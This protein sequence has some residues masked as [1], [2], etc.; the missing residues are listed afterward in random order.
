MSATQS[1]LIATLL[2][3]LTPAAAAQSAAQPAPP[4]LPDPG[5][6]VLWDDHDPDALWASAATYKACFAADRVDYIPLLGAHAPSLPLRLELAEVTAGAQRVRLSRA[7]PT[8]HG[9]RVELD[10]GPVRERWELGPTQAEQSFVLHEP[11]SPGDLRLSLAVDTELEFAGTDGEGLRFSAR[12]ATGKSLGE[13]RYGHATVLDARGR[14]L[15]SPVRWDG[16]AIVIHV[17]G[18]FLEQAAWPVTIDPV[19]QTFAVAAN[20]REQH[21]SDSTYV[22][23]A[24]GNLWVVVYEERVSLIDQDIIARRY[25]EAGRFVDELA[26]EVAPSL[27]GRPSVATNGSQARAVI[28]WE[29]IAANGNK[30][31]LAREINGNGSLG[32]AFTVAS[33]TVD[34]SLPDV[35]GATNTAVD[36]NLSLIVWEAN[37]TAT[38]RDVV[39]RIYDSN[40]RT[41][42]PLLTLANSTAQ[43]RNARVNKVRSSGD[44]W[45]VVFEAG[46]QVR[47][48]PVTS[49]GT[50]GAAFDFGTGAVD[51]QPDVAGDGTSFLVVVARTVGAATHDLFAR[52]LQRRGLGFTGPAAFDLTAL[53]PG[54]VP[55]LDQ[56]SPRIDHDGT[57]YSY[58][59]IE[60]TAASGQ[61][62]MAATLRDDGS[63]LFD[64]G[65]VQVAAGPL[66]HMEPAI[67]ARRSGNGG[68]GRYLVTV[69][70]P[71]STTPF[72][73]NIDALLWNGTAPQG[74]VQ[75]LVTGCG[76]TLG[77]GPPALTLFEESLPPALGATLQ[78]FL[79]AQ[80]G[81]IP[82]YLVGFPPSSLPIPLCPGAGS[83]K[84]G[85]TTF[86]FVLSANH[87]S[88]PIPA[89][90]NLLGARLAVQGMEVFT[91]AR[92]GC[93]LTFN[94]ID[95]AMTNTLEI[96]IQ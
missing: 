40:S 92:N 69:S 80:G 13:V 21:H 46:T 42:G 73:T 60:A 70:E 77:G 2:S 38:G 48:V 89:D 95:F 55:G 23:L 30:D 57:R 94:P 37:N 76:G 83:C 51:S 22:R 74:G 90:G 24:S 19:V 43:E 34:Q 5:R 6:R 44:T 15:S 11:T 20:T 62:V 68:A 53:E 50:V 85:V 78:F 17:P 75:S 87:L 82:L 18:W 49:G 36:N 91:G 67:T 79:P 14:T 10:H 93:G 54:A 86:L 9:N 35:G 8:R 63:N 4:T 81:G 12:A 59:Y 64:E 47:C 7:A 72:D 32:T 41:L 84:L 58:V 65:H 71:R 27:S 52:R 31:I 61:Q 33:G 66:E 16:R 39:A 1:I 25:D 88:L 96:T 56:S 28:A 3:A 29:R 26:I 45:M